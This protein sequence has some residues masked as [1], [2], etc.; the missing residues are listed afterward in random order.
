MS[1]VDALF[2]MGNSCN[3]VKRSRTLAAVVRKNVEDN[4]M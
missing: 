1:K 2:A 3:E 4:A